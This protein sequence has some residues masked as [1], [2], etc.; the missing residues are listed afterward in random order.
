MKRSTLGVYQFN[1]AVGAVVLICVAL[2]IG[3]LLNAGLLK[4]WFE[5]SLTLRIMLPEEGTSGL[6]QGSEVQILGTRAGEIRRI[7][8]DP[9]QHMHAE[10]RIDTQMKPFLRRDS[11]VV[12]RR[13]FGIAGN[14]YVDITRGRGPEL[15]WDFAVLT[16][17]SDRAPTD[18]IGQVVDDV[19]SRIVPILDQLQKVVASASALV[20]PSGALHQT[21]QSA[22]SVAQ[23]VE[24]GEG[25]VGKLLADDKMATDLAATLTAAQSAVAHTNGLVA[26]LEKSTKDAK[27][28]SILQRTDAILGSLQ[29]VTRNLAAA[30]PNIMTTTD[31]MPALLLQTE[32]TARELELLLGQL[33]R[34]WLLGGG[35]ATPAS[36]RRAPASEV[37]P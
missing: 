22:A 8:I 31:S 21:L 17:N 1:Q 34:S 2:F 10:A 3:A 24:R 27:I 25:S 28:A 16:A 13:Q 6:S 37:R 29:V 20:G 33:R 4:E 32:S 18:S 35:G 7:V 19:R 36:S 9:S 23:R 15:D 5:T 12:I 30:S 14:A 11:Q 26:E